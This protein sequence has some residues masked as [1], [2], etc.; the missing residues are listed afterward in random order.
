MSSR[1]SVVAGSNEVTRMDRRTF[2]KAGAATLTVGTE[3]LAAPWSARADDKPIRVGLMAPL[4]GVV[5]AGGREI[6]DGFT[7]F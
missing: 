4:T 2:L 3:T 1:D 7:M 6:V 5:A